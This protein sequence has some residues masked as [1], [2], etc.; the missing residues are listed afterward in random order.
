MYPPL[1]G[2]DGMPQPPPGYA[3]HPSQSHQG[4]QPMGGGGV[5]TQQQPMM[6]QMG[7]PPGMGG[8]PHG[9]EYLTQLDQ[10]I[11]KQKIEGLEAVLGF[12]SQNKY[13]IR[14]SM[15]QVRMI[16]LSLFVRWVII[17]QV[18]LM[19]LLDSAIALIHLSLLLRTIL[20]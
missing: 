17:V 1:E 14:N 6:M 20:S 9:L 19:D 11:V 5:V 13:I 16:S 12:E 3:P 8:V 18:I 15:G 4:H 10:L 7:P 2:Q